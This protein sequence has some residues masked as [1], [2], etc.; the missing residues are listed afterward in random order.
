M[1]LIE[2][3]FTSQ[4]V[5]SDTHPYKSVPGSNGTEGTSKEA[6]AIRVSN[7]HV[8]TSHH[9]KSDINL[10]IGSYPVQRHSTGCPFIFEKYPVFNTGLQMLSIYVVSLFEMGYM[11]QSPL[12]AKPNNE[13][14]I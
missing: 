8:R 6:L 1:Y 4:S 7:N 9:K 13:C 3:S 14:N 10:Y 12:P 5:T 2:T 11:T